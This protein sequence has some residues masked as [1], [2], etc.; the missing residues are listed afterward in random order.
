MLGKGDMN[1]KNN[2]YSSWAVIIILFII[3]WPVG[4]IL[5]YLKLKSESKNKFIFGGK[6]RI[7]C[8][9]CSLLF[10][11]LGISVEISEPSEDTAI[12]ITLIIIFLALGAFLVKI[13][14]D[15]IRAGKIYDKI[16]NLINI[17]SIEKVQDISNILGF[18]ENKTLEYIS[19]TI[20]LGLCHAKIDYQTKK[21][22]N[23]KQVNEKV[24][25]KNKEHI[26]K[27]ECCGGIN[28]VIE[29]NDNVCEYCG[30]ELYV[31]K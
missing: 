8:G 4:L 3:F 6:V 30:M 12:G 14:I 9:V 29:D 10:A 21:I 1:S 28:K 5:A 25:K 31:K 22:I 23:E 7:I 2:V 19:K 11:L 15:K 13:G 16:A 26:I 18:N 20:E 24:E 17:Q 27:C